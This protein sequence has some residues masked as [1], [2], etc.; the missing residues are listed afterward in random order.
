MVEIIEENRRPSFTDSLLSGARRAGTQLVEDL[1]LKGLTGKTLAGL[2]P[3]MKRTFAE[4]L[5]KTPG[6]EAIVKSLVNQGVAPEE[7]DF[8]AHLT[9]GGQTAF[10]KDLLESKKRDYFL[11]LLVRTNFERGPS[12]QE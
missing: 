11:D 7:A 3:D 1:S 8:Y 12:A 4:R 10:V 5:A 9:T 6:H 2:S